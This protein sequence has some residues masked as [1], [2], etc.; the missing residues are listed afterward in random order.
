MQ[1]KEIRRL[2]ES[3]ALSFCLMWNKRGYLVQDFLGLRA[4]TRTL[5]RW[6]N[7][8][9]LEIMIEPMVAALCSNGG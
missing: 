7:L 9:C 6:R 3:K 5:E 1:L 2:G 4:S 8:V